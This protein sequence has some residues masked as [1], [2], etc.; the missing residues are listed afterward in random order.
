[1]TE[2]DEL[3]KRAQEAMI[4]RDEALKAS[5]RVYA[6]AGRILEGLYRFAGLDELAD[7]IRLTE[8]A[9]RR[10]EAGVES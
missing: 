9:P 2:V 8:R 4:A 5:R 10:A 3:G 6:N 7:R 1:M